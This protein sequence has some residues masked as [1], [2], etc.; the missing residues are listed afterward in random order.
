M[1]YVFGSHQLPKWLWLPSSIWKEECCP[2]DHFVC[3]LL[4]KGRIV[5]KRDQ[6]E[7]I[8]EGGGVRM[9]VGLEK[10]AEGL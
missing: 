4:S 2:E 3:R 9:G 1:D 5:S 10:V 8:R 7:D 6:E